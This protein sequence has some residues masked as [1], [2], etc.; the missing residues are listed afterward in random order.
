M[1]MLILIFI[2]Y[3]ITDRL[4]EVVAFWFTITRI[5]GT[6]F[7][8]NYPKF[9]NWLLSKDEYELYFESIFV[10]LL[11]YPFRDLYHTLK[12]MQ[13]LVG[14]VCIGYVAESWLVVTFPIFW[15]IFQSSVFWL[16]IKPQYW[17]DEVWKFWRK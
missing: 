14:L 1:L 17:T 7:E 8:K 13:I 2:F 15:W 11:I 3:A 10:N 12:T 16:C 6:E 9:A 4:R 5:D